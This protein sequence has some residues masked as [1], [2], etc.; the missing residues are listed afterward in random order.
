[1]FLFISNVMIVSACMLIASKLEETAGPTVD[2]FVYISDSSYT[3]KE[4]TKMEL[5]I[6]SSLCF[7]LRYITP[8]DF[9]DRFLRASSASSQQALCC[10]QPTHPTCKFM[11]Q[12]LLELAAMCYDLVAKPPSMIAASAVFLA[13]ATLGICDPQ[14]N[15]ARAWSKT[16]CHYTGYSVCELQETVRIIFDAQK[17]A[18]QNDLKSVFTKYKARKYERIALKTVLND[19]QLLFATY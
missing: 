15:D 1:M 4:I 7:H 3:R 6:C 9:V 18:E 5:R 12:Y 16:L 2:D 10:T 17:N 11:V 14:E 19:D 13:R 8:F